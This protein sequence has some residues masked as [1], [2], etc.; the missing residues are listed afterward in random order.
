[1]GHQRFWVALLYHSTKVTRSPCSAVTDRDNS[2]RREKDC[3][4]HHRTSHC[5]T[6]RRTHMAAKCHR[7]PDM[8]CDQ[9]YCTLSTLNSKVSPGHTAH[10]RFPNPKRCFEVNQTTRQAVRIIL[11]VILRATPN[12]RSMFYMNLKNWTLCPKA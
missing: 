6:C 5:F 8:F 12:L 1:M 4:H 10:A 9:K 2:K 11:V 7:A 3:T